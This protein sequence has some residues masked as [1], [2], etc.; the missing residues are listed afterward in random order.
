M[1]TL[2]LL[3]KTF[4]YLNDNVFN[5]EE[6]D[7]LSDLIVYSKYCVVN[8]E[9]LNNVSSNFQLKIAKRQLFNINEYDMQELIKESN[10]LKYADLKDWN[11]IKIEEILD[12][13]EHKN[14]LINELYKQR[15]F[16]KILYVLMPSK[17]EF[18]KLSWKKDHMTYASVSNKLFKI[19]SSCQEGIKYLDTSPEDNYFAQNKTWYEDVTEN[20][21]QLCD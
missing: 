2:N 17:E 13:V 4:H 8:Y 5:E 7:I 10:V 14:S 16:K 6:L 12:I 11:W 3:Q 9:N 18:I 15:F 19:F 1:H 21:E 20:L